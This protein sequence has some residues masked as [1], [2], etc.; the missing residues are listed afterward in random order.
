MFDVFDINLCGGL[1]LG[2]AV[3]SMQ[4]RNKLIGHAATFGQM[5]SRQ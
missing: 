2:D 5:L 1:Q 3:Y 4:Y